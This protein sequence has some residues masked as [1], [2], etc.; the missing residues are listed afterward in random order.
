MGLDANTLLVLIVWLA[1]TITAGE[2]AYA[3]GVDRVTL[4]AY[5]AEA[6]A[7]GLRLVHKARDLAVV[8]SVVGRPAKGRDESS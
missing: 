6:Y 5:R 8:P 7:Q 4:Y 1:D 2:A 3:L